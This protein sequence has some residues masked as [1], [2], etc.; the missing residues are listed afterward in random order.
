[1]VCPLQNQAHAFTLAHKGTSLEKLVL[2][3]V[4]K[5]VLQLNHCTTIELYLRCPICKLAG[6]FIY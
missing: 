6:E 1:M 3:N 5:N 4:Y 2:R